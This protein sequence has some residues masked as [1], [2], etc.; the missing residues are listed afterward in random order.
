MW[1]CSQAEPEAQAVTNIDKAS[2][3]VTDAEKTTGKTETATQ[4]VEEDGVSD[5]VDAAAAVVKVTSYA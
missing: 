1:S 2:A 5:E 4:S 3:A